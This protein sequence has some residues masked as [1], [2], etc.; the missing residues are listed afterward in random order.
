MI[1]FIEALQK[2]VGEKNAQIGVMKMFE[3]FQDKKLNKHLVYVNIFKI[4]FNF[5]IF[6][7]LLCVYFKTLIELFVSEMC[8]PNRQEK[9]KI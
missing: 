9:T 6:N 3:T 5:K 7:N 8:Q 1:N 4:F 2:L